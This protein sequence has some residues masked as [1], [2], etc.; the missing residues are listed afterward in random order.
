MAISNIWPPIIASNNFT[1]GNFLG[2]A[3]NGCEIILK[4]ITKMASFD[5][6]DNWMHYTTLIMENVP[7]LDPTTNPNFK[8]NI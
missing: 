4:M 1:H 7:T 5:S 6:F 3:W 8:N 2:D